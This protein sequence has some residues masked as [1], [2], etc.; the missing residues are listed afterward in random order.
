VN[1]RQTIRIDDIGAGVFWVAVGFIAAAMLFLTA[2]D[3]TNMTQDAA[4][5]EQAAR[6][7]ALESRLQAIEH[8]REVES[9]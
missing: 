9:K 3:A 6:I 8:P 5:R 1:G 4:I 7:A 2:I